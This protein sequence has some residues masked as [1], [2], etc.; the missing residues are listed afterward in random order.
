[1]E[2]ILW[3]SLANHACS[4]LLQEYVYEEELCRVALTCRLALDVICL[5]SRPCDRGL[6]AVKEIWSS[7]MDDEIEEVF[8]DMDDS[9]SQDLEDEWKSW[10]VNDSDLESD[11]TAEEQVK[12]KRNKFRVTLRGE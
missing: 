11:E 5:M 10:R 8:S 3:C 6:T 9:Y 4:P 2:N 12:L 7:H 1:M